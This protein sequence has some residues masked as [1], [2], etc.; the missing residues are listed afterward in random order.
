MTSGGI[1]RHAQEA[2]TGPPHQILA[3]PQ[4]LGLVAGS[5][6]RMDSDVVGEV[7]GGMI[8]CP[9]SAVGPNING[10]PPSITVMPCCRP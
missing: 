3:C 4:Q 10:Q 2:G 1:W 7:E 9:R 6:N 5:S 8:L